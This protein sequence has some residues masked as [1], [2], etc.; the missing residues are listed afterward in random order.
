MQLAPLPD[1]PNVWSPESGGHL[2]VWSSE[3]S[4]HI[5]SHAQYKVYSIIPVR[6]RIKQELFIKSTL[7]GLLADGF[8]KLISY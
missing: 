3:A 6:G 2:Y 7:F 5:T 1:A 8:C 4:G